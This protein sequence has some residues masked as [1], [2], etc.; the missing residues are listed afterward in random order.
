MSIGQKIIDAIEKR[1]D[2]Q[3]KLHP[4]AIGHFQRNGGDRLLYDLPVITGSLVI[5]GGGY[6]GE[7]SAEIIARYG[8]KILVFEPVPQFA[9]HLQKYF[10]NNQLV[11]IIMK[12]LGGSSRRTTF[13]YL[14]NGT[15]EYRGDDAKEHIT[16]DVV[17]IVRIFEEMG[18]ARIACLKLN[19]EGGEYE[20]LER[21]IE[22]NKVE[23]C[24]SLLIQ[25]HRQPK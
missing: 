6:K 21:M 18:G 17:D 23:L 2:E 25:F 15:S 11:T 13:N 4:G 12:A 9:E 3:R 20:V 19:V 5:D 24:D 1:R 22:T 7:W 14:D 10:K 16:A 8:C